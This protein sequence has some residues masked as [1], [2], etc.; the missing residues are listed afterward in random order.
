M[1]YHFHINNELINRK[2]STEKKSATCRVLDDL[3]KEAV[4]IG[5]EV[6]DVYLFDK[7]YTVDEDS[8]DVI[9]LGEDNGPGVTKIKNQ[10]VY[11]V[12]GQTVILVVC[13]I[14]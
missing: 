8:D 10:A 5:G 6:S 1:I 9:I 13:L 14:L 3:I 2:R 7:V 4:R 12:I 11:I